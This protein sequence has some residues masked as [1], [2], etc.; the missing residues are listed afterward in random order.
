MYLSIEYEIKIEKSERES[1]LKYER[2]IRQILLKHSFFF[3]R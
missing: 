1:Y 3:F 2:E